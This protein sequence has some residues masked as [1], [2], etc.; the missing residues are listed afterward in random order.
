V[1]LLKG[2]LEPSQTVI[3]VAA[4]NKSLSVVSHDMLGLFVTLPSPSH[5]FH[6]HLRH[7]ALAN[8]PR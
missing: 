4:T 3:D 7:N 8:F 5:S 1:L 6:N 2:A